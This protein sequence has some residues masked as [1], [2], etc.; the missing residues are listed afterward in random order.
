MKHAK[1]LTAFV[2]SVNAGSFSA[3]AALLGVTPAA[4]SKSIQTVEQDL[5][6]R[7]FHRTTR[8]LALTEEGALL[9]ERCRGALQDLDSA[10]SAL[11]DSRRERK[12]T[13][14]VTLPVLF[15]RHIVLPLVPAFNARHPRVTLDVTLDDRLSELDEEGYDVG[16]RI[17]FA[18]GAGVS[19]TRIG[20]L[21]YI[22][23][24]SPTYF[25]G[26]RA[27]PRTPDDLLQHNCIRLRRP[28]ARRVTK[29]EFQ[30]N[31]ELFTREVSGNLVV[32]D[33]EGLCHAVV[34]GSGLGQIPGF[35]AAPLIASG[36][37]KPVLLEHLSDSRS[38]FV[39]YPGR[40]NLGA[41]ERAFVDFLVENLKGNLRLLSKEDTQLTSTKETTWQ[42][43]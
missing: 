41:M 15:G 43:G 39:C 28:G 22:V 20:P 3:A 25:F 24:G 9:F 1:N 17:D 27:I 42:H 8:R 19:A 13:L 21:Q 40:K 12:A 6:V 37:L 32:N 36:Q 11:R 33:A 26:D 16:V 2:K 38:I 14:R 31:G 5:G 29:W 4:V 35:L 7:L 30:R 10:M 34:R 18:A 23:C